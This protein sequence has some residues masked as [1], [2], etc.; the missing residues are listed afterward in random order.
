MALLDRAGY[1]EGANNKL[2]SRKIGGPTRMASQDG[3]DG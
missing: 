2:F 1:V 3:M